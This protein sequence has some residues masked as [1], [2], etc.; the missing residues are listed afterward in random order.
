[1]RVKIAE[2]L[3]E[4]IEDLSFIDRLGGLVKPLVVK[5]P[6]DK[7]GVILKRMPVEVN[8]LTYCDSNDYK[9]FVPDDQYKSVIFFEDLGTNPRDQKDSHL[10]WLTTELRMVCWFNLPKINVGYT[11]CDLLVMK[12]LETMPD[13]VD[14]TTEIFGITIS[15]NGMA[16]NDIDLFE[17]Y[18]FDLAE[19]Q[20]MNYPYDVAGLNFSVDY[21]IGRNCI[22]LTE[23]PAVC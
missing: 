4:Q 8:S 7:E 10:Y 18:D 12:I 14:N 17:D 15:F 13:S 11:D 5:D 6:N 23:S 20:Y 2:I 3:K 9:A 21:A 1:M 19:H 22:T 16:G